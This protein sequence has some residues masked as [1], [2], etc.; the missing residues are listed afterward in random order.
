MQ[1]TDFK[2][3]LRL[4]ISTLD[5]TQKEFA[6]FTGVR[7]ASISN[8]C[9]GVSEPNQKNLNKIIQATQVNPSWLMGYGED[10]DITV[11]R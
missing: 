6:Q 2:C 1:N 10:E 3:R 11:L 8:Y 9:V 4:L 5:M 7:E